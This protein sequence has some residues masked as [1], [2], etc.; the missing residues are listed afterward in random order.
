MMIVDDKQIII[1]SANINDRSMAGDRDSEVCVFI[2]DESFTPSSSDRQHWSTGRFAKGA[3]L[4][5]WYELFGV[6]EEESTQDEQ[7]I[8]E[9][10]QYREK[11][12]NPCSKECWEFWHDIAW[13]RALAFDKRGAWPSKHTRNWTEFRELLVLA[14]SSIG[15]PPPPEL[16]P[17]PG[18]P[19]P[20]VID[21]PLHF[22]ADLDIRLPRPRVISALTP[23]DVLV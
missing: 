20:I 11:L 10:K 12:E 1:G 6:L 22:L 15:E 16:N 2:E 13:K 18:W 17:P 7:A 4:R 5:I 9:W 3:R 21:F 23:K 8:L 14:R 19:R